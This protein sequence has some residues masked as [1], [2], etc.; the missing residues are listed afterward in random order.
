MALIIQDL[1]DEVKDNKDFYETIL[2]TKNY[3]N[4]VK[5]SMDIGIRQDEVI[6]EDTF[7]LHKAIITYLLSKGIIRKEKTNGKKRLPPTDI[8]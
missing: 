2:F 8:Q 4:F 7:R 1:I 3:K 6:D 5:Y